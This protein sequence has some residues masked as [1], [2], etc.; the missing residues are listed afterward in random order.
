MP[1][2][3]PMTLLNG[4]AAAV[5]AGIVPEFRVTE[6][7]PRNGG[8]VNAVYE[9]RGEGGV[10][11]LIIKIY[12][13]RWHSTADRWRSKLAKE[14]YV[15]RLL[16][17]QG[18]RQIPRVL[19]YEAAG[20][21]AL[22]SAFA[23]LT[24]LDGRPLSSAGD[25]LTGPEVDRVYREMGELLAAVH[26][27]TADRWGY[28]ATSIVD[29]KPSNTAYML[30]QFATKLIRFADLGGEPA[31]AGAIGRHVAARA[32]VFAGCRQP[33]L[34]HNDFHDGNV[35]VAETTHGW[36]VTGFVDVENSVVADP[37]F[38]LAKTDYYALR[39]NQGKRHAF[40]RG[41]G[42]LPPD[43]AERIEVYRLHHALEFWNWSAST[44]KLG[45]LPEIR[46]DLE[47]II[48]SGAP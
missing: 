1:D 34:C 37:L 4:A 27:I 40:L 28:V 35:L 31:M 17:R 44:G 23:V 46:S 39:D 26:R 25:R 19:R 48:G 15:Y 11:P 12:P 5:L 13:E 14:V 33:T 6:V 9:V 24:L 8:E 20:V 2:H 16:A 43:W 3:V 10:R 22:P 38:D 45:L 21:P 18:I 29:S 41:Y 42:P 32:D 7:V 36:R 47:N 30:D